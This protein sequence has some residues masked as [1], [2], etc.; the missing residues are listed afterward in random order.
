MIATTL[1][2]MRAAAAALLVM[3]TS[4]ASAQTP[5]PADA[6]PDFS[7]EVWGF[8]A[9]DFSKRVVGYVE[10]RRTLEEGLPRQTVTKDPEA[11]TPPQVALAR[12]IRDARDDAD[13]GDI[14]TPAISAEFRRV[15]K[16]E[17]DAETLKAIM[18]DNPGEFGHRINGWY[19]KAMS[20]STVPPNILAVLPRLPE[21]V[22]YR[23]LGRHLILYDRR[24]NLILDRLPHAIECDDCD[25]GLLSDEP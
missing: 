12:R 17:T 4:A 20:L 2:V 14:F 6:K 16:R 7:V 9:A 24:A 23:F 1:T 8:L 15:L 13:Q 22:Q 11:L 10:L 21:D 25:E 19:P 18:D 3:L 5:A